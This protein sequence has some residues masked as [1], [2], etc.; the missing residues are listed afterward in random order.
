MRINLSAADVKTQCSQL[1]LSNLYYI[2]ILNYF[3]R[4]LLNAFGQQEA[5]LTAATFLDLVLNTFELDKPHEYAGRPIASCQAYVEFDSFYYKAHWHADGRLMTWRNTKFH[6]FKRNGLKFEP[7]EEHINILTEKIQEITGKSFELW[8]D[9]V[10]NPKFDWKAFSNFE[11]ILYCIHCLG[12][13]VD[14]NII[15]SF[16]EEIN[17]GYSDA[18]IAALKK[19]EAGLN[20]TQVEITYF[21][22]SA[23]IALGSANFS[24]HEIGWNNILYS[25]IRVDPTGDSIAKRSGY[26]CKLEPEVFREFFARAMFF[27]GLYYRY[28]NPLN[29][30]TPI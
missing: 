20:K 13:D 11:D 15:L 28:I 1:V 24:K 2:D 12:I 3:D 18:K 4:W 14:K 9:C 23:K 30:K 26:I 27:P 19:N 16:P 10:L 21:D 22:R 5:Q 7:T 17:K 8:D 29:E 25:E 6:L